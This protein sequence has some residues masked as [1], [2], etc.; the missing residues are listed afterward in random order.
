MTPRAPFV[1]STLLSVLATT[2]CAGPSRE[3]LVGPDQLGLIRSTCTT[4][5][6]IR[7]GVDL[8]ACTRSLANTVV[9]LRE[10]GSVGRADSDCARQGVPRGTPEFTMCTLDNRRVDFPT[11]AAPPTLAYDPQRD[12]PEGYYSASFDTKRRREKIACAQLGIGLE[13][14]AFGDCVANLDAS[15]FHADNPYR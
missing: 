1:A 6:H 4:V 10:D 11:A 12:S 8:E 7:N 2:N 15:L 14:D 9:A 13:S 3:R 5:M